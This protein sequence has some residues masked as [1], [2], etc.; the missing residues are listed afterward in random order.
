VNYRYAFINNGKTEAGF[1]AGISW[2]AF[3]ISLEGTGEVD[4]GMNPPVIREVSTSETLGIPVPAFGMFINHAFS[5]KWILRMSAGVLN[6]DVGD[7][8]GRY[9]TTSVTVDYIITRHFGLGGGFMRQDLDFANTG[10]QNPY[11]I[12]YRLG[13]PTLY[14]SLVF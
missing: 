6:L 4:D 12:G 14:F 7:Y 1:T 2:F 9:V 8:E 5:K 11:T 13:G 10:G 3:D